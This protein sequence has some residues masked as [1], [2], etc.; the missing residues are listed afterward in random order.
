MYVQEGM[1]K[2][3]RLIHVNTTY[4]YPQMIKSRIACN[5]LYLGSTSPTIVK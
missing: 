4:K 1:L 2:P 5:N 3:F